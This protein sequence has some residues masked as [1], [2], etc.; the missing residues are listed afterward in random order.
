M[1]FPRVRID[2]SQP[3]EERWRFMDAAQCTAIHALTDTYLKDLGS[4][5]DIAAQIAPIAAEHLEPTVLQELRSLAEHAH[6]DESRLLLANLYYDAFRI[7]I[8]C[9]AFAIDGPDGPIHAR[10]L[11]WWAPNRLLTSTTWIAEFVGGA[12]GTFESVAWPGMVGTFSGIAK[13]RFAITMNAVVS[14]EPAEPA[15]SIAMLIRRAFETCPDFDAAVRL[16]SETRITADCLLLVTGA[17]EGELVVVERT[18]SRAEL[19]TAENG[20][21][22]VTNDYRAMPGE[23]PEHAGELQR[24]ADSRFLRAHQL[25]HWKRPTS[26]EACLEILSDPKV[27]MD[28][29]VQQMFMHAASG[30]LVVKDP[31]G[32]S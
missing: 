19:R 8:G 24:T 22:V 15:A 4:L 20:I 31:R 32:H 14:R 10:N 2:L 21:L 6:I 27:R 1:P 5:A 11:D 9:T 25:T 23:A 18:S 29:T 16:L 26:P 7:L 12:H 28:M 30:T 17:R 13:G 3:P